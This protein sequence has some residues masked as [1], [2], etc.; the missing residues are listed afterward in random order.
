MSCGEGGHTIASVCV[1][2][3]RGQHQVLTF[4]LHIFEAVFC[5]LARKLLRIFLSSTPILLG[6]E[7]HE[8][9]PDFL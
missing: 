6:L 2:G 4:T 1:V 9:M 5:S 7:V 3:V 8:T